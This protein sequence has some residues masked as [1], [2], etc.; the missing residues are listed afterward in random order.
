MKLNLYLFCAALVL[1]SVTATAQGQEVDSDLANKI[2][3]PVADL[4]SL[5]FQNNTDFGEHNTNTLN[6]QPVLPFKMSKNWNL[7]ARTIIPIV[8]AYDGFDRANG[9]G[10]ITLS[11]F[12]TPAKP[13]K[14]IWGVGPTFMFPAIENKVGYEKLGIAPSAVAMYQN[15]GWTLGCL[16]QNFWGV[17]GPS[18][19]ADLNLFYTQIFVTKN[20]SKGWYVNSAPIIT[21]NWEANQ[22]HRWTVPL[23]AGVGKLFTIGKLPINAQIGGYKYLEHPGDADWQLRTQI[24]LLFPK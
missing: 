23:G 21:A 20:L 1:F 9:I 10:N 24:T 2:Q 18:A 17:A 3:N 13:K 4:I 6:I 8:S 14:M 5:P 15:N 12:L 7:I 11:T 16:A 22:D 19:A